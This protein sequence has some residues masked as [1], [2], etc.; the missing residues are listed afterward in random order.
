MVMPYLPGNEISVDCLNTASGLIAI[1]RY[2]GSA[3]HERILF[4]ED[5]LKM[6][7]CIMNRIQLQ[8]PCNIQF[9]VSE[10]IPYLLEINTR[11]SGGLQMACLAENINI[12]NIALN[13]LLGKNV[14]WSFTPEE[15]VVSYIEVPKV[16]R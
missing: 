11:M 5:I 12:P 6:T 16:I 2:K 8:Y 7:R 4:D 14:D 3:R 9:K 13:K 15:K 1:P 10:G